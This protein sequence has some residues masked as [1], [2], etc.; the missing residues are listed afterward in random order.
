MGAGLVEAYGSLSGSREGLDVSETVDQLRQLLEQLL[1]RLA[2]VESSV[3]SAS[4]ASDET[5]L[6]A[7]IETL[8]RKVD[9]ASELLAEFTD[10]LESQT[11][12]IETIEER[13]GD[14]VFEPSDSSVDDVNETPLATEQAEREPATLPPQ[15]DDAVE[16]QELG[17][18]AALERLAAALEPHSATADRERW[19][20][21]PVDPHGQTVGDVA[22]ASSPSDEPDDRARASEIAVGAVESG[23]VERASDVQALAERLDTLESIVL[24]FLEIYAADPATGHDEPAVAPTSAASVASDGPAGGT[25]D[26]RT[27]TRLVESASAAAAEGAAVEVREYLEPRLRG[28]ELRIDQIEARAAE[29]KRIVSGRERQVR[30]LEERLLILVDADEPQ[31]LGGQDEVASDAS[32]HA[33]LLRRE[34]PGEARSEPASTSAASET[35]ADAEPDSAQARLAELVEREFSLKREFRAGGVLG[36]SSPEFGGGR[37]TVMI[38]DDSADA[39]TILSMFLSKTGFHVVSAISAEDCLAKLRHHHIDALILDASMPGANGGY[40]CR[41]L[42][43]DGTYSDLRDLPIIVYTAYP[44]DYSRDTVRSWGADEYVVKGGDLVPLV[45]ALLRHTRSRS[46]AHP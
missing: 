9:A 18:L 35:A 10:I 23:P 19:L 20:D 31:T 26:E 1:D 36:P 5:T 28:L 21:D 29:L 12:R 46:E 2:V 17:I 32:E 40:V 43:H 11:E 7:Q 41:T 15:E 39:R 6:D 14:P 30:D 3:D 24:D 45:N 37:P 16:A 4:R 13:L 22:T 25:L 42:R 8:G 27:A 33:P 38:V 34:P 44:D